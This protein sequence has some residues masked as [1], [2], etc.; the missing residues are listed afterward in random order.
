MAKVNKNEYKLIDELL[1]RT[2]RTFYLT[3]RFLPKS[4]RWSFSLGYL[5]ARAT[6]STADLL[7][8]PSVVR[9]SLL[10]LM[11]DIINTGPNS[12][13]ISQLQ[14]TAISLT[15]NSTAHILLMHF[16]LVVK[17]LY[18]LDKDSQDD[19]LQLL[20]TITTGQQFDIER[21]ASSHDKVVCLQTI[22]ELDHYTYL[23]AGS[24][25]EYWT[26][27]C[28][29][30]IPNYSSLPAAELHS[31][32]IPFGKALQLVNVLRDIPPDLA[33]GRCYMPLE[34]L[35]QQNLSPDQL[36]AEIQRL[37]PIVKY[38]WSKARDNLQVGWKYMLSIN[39]PR[40][41]Y[42]IAM[43]L[44]LGFGTL[45]LLQDP[46]YLTSQ[47]PAKLTHLQVKILMLIAGLGMISRKFFI[48]LRLTKFAS[49]FNF[50]LYQKS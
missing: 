45:H 49:I 50:N 12:D 36:P 5:L 13:K 1:R 47:Q 37:E 34:Q 6:D 32:A 3:L 20:N 10:I 46:H 48:L 8:Q 25:G 44:L 21:F 27:V 14:A 9:L 35:Q 39:S 29:K 2:S 30:R 17:L 16:D 23:V 40:M 42:A 43:P 15:P 19:I 28:L 18:Q 38:W 33:F 41:R 31:L 24:V 7:D 4:V 26:K 11:K 22:A